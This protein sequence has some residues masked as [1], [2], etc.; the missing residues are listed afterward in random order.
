MFMAFAALCWAAGVHADFNQCLGLEMAT[1]LTTPSCMELFSTCQL[2]VSKLNQ[3]LGVAAA[4]AYKPVSII[5]AS[6]SKMVTEN[7]TKVAMLVQLAP[8]TDCLADSP[9]TKEDSCQFDMTKVEFYSILL[10]HEFGASWKLEGYKRHAL[11]GKLSLHHFRAE[12]WHSCSYGYVP[13]LFEDDE[14]A[15]IVEEYNSGQFY[16]S[17]LAIGIFDAPGEPLESDSKATAPRTPTAVVAA[18]VTA[19]FCLGLVLHQRRRYQNGYAPI[20]LTKGGHVQGKKSPTAKGAPEERSL[21]PDD[22]A[23][24]SAGG[25]TFKQ[26][27]NE[28]FAV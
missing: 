25:H 24:S 14:R 11:S 5:S 9:T 8:L 26:E 3:K 1:L 28:R 4:E 20:Y 19:L 16:G 18:S 15:Q 13:L 22:A 12:F 21:R 6:E 17:K 10:T 27:A 23:G 7:S 2:G